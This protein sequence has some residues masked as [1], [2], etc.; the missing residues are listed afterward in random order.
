MEKV[1]VKTESP[2]VRSCCLDGNDVC[3]GCYRTLNEILN[4]VKSPEQDKQL[5]ISN[6]EFRKREREANQQ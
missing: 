4:W 6:C 1:V 2:C 3:L 5:I